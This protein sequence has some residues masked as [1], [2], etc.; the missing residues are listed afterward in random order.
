[1]QWLT[2][3]FW[4]VIGWFGA[5]EPAVL[6]ALLVGVG[7]TWVFIKTADE[8]FEGETR[9]FDMWV[10]KSLRTP[11]QLDQPI[12]PPWLAEI[13]RDATAFGGIAALTFFT[14]AVSGFLWLDRKYR[15]L[16]FLLAATA[17]GLALSLLLKRLFHRPRPDLVPHLSYVYTTSFPSGHSLLSTVVYLTL[18]TLVASVVPRWPLKI[19]VVALAVVL[20][21]AVGISRVFLGVHYPTD[22]LA[23]WAAGLTWA[24]FCW[25]IARKLQRRGQLETAADE[26]EVQPP[27]AS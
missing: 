8:V 18:G 9:H 13:G 7:G 27:P 20:C 3:T 21:V 11:G 26:P 6:C 12:G 10:L 14:V 5:I 1:M 23:G 19:Y 25:L 4:R 16:V 17:T 24:I 2:R 15:M 22:V